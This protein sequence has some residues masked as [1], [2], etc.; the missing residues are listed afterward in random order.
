MPPT[1]SASHC[2]SRPAALQRCRPRPARSGSIDNL[3]IGFALGAYHF[4]LAAA[5]VIIGAVSVTLSQVGLELGDRLSTKTG[6]RGELL[7][8]PGLIDVGIVTASGIQ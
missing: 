2:W 1:G 8:S 3:A 5:A 6:E 7:G 4:N